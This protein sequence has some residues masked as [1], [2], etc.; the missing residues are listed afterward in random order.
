MLDAGLS[1][2]TQELTAVFLAVRLWCSL[3]MEFN[4]HTILDTATLAVTLWVVYTIRFKLKA[5]SDQ[6]KD[7]LPM[8]YVLVPCAVLALLV[9]PKTS[10]HV[11]NRV[12]WAFCVYLESV[13]VLP[14][15][16]VMQVLP[17][18]AL[19]TDASRKFSCMQFIIQQAFPWPCKTTVE[20]R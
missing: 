20:S 7:N 12:L 14:Q 9:H 2:K 18:L 4:T 5:A 1:L 17:S 15:L 10:H 11:I 3:M 19:I 8:S 6:S 13:S 16:R